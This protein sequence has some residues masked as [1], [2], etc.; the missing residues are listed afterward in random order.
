MKK[1]VKSKK[2][3]LNEGITLIALVV[4]IVVL[5][6]LAGT[7]I[8]MLAGEDGIITQAK[9]AKDKTTI[10]NEKDLVDLSV[11]AAQLSSEWGEITETN[12]EKELT[13]NIGERDVDYTLTKTGDNYTV[14]YTETG[15]SYIVY[16]DGSTKER[17]PWTQE[18]KEEDGSISITNGKITLEVGDV[19]KNYNPVPEGKTAETV[20]SYST[21]NGYGNQTFS[22]DYDAGAWRVLGVSEDGKLMI[23]PE[24]IIKTTSDGYYYLQ[25]QAGYVN[26]VSELDKISAIFGKGYGAESARSV[27]VEDINR[28]TGYNPNNVGVYD[29][30]QIGSGMKYGGVAD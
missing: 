21:E 29:P 3:I 22:A 5:L 11:V 30:D 18:K 12:L 13:I 20:T 24:N 23:V 9:N 10:G 6:I 25:G 16:S 26:A 17:G 19:I 27:K 2:K 14:T 8:Q 15:N 7:S 1:V 28:V 4:T